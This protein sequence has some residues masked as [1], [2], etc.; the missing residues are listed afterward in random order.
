MIIRDFTRDP[1][2]EN[3]PNEALQ[4]RNASGFVV[5]RGWCFGLAKSPLACLMSDLDWVLVRGCSLSIP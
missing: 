3:Y 1:N 2:L 4:T 5:K